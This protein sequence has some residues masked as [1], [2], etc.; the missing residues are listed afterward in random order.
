MDYFLRVINKN[1]RDHDYWYEEMYDAIIVAKGHY[2]IPHIPKVSGLVE[3]QQQNSDIIQHTRSFRKASDYK[4]KKILI[5]GT[6][7]SATDLI[8]D[9]LGLSKSP[10]LVSSRRESGEA[11]KYS[12]GNNKKIP[13]KPE[14]SKIGISDDRLTVDI[15]FVDWSVVKNVEIVIF[16]TGYLYDLPFFRQN[17]VA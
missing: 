16:A 11:F 8:S 14:I 7:T 15:K 12:F 3:L 6:G 13:I 9:V 1:D 4:D 5:V 10:I 2:S 17:E